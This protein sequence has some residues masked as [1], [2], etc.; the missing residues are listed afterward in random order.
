MSTPVNKLSNSGHYLRSKVCREP[1]QTP[2]LQMPSSP[3]MKRLGFGTGVDVFL[4]E[5]SPKF[6]KSMSPW[7]IKKISKRCNGIEEVKRLKVEASILKELNH[8]NIVGFRTFAK[9]HDGLYCLAMEVG[10]MSLFDLIELKNEADESPFPSWSI[11]KVALSITSALDYLHNE[12]YILHGDIKSGNV[13]I[14]GEFDYVKLCHFGVALPLNNDL[15]LSKEH[16]YVGTTCWS[17]KEAIE[18]GLITDRTDIFAFGIT[19]Y[20]ML[21]LAMPHMYVFPEEEL[22]DDP[23]EFEKDYEVAEEKFHQL[24]GTRPPLLTNKHDKSYATCI[25]VFWVCTNSLPIER[26]S[27]K[28]LYEALM[29]NEDEIAILPDPKG[30][31]EF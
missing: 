21:T 28:Q 16:E 11:M 25:E 15:T 6:G 22:Y 7:A 5:R 30:K 23:D 20:E 8:E 12:K 13:L 10:K 4:I 29:S 9:S 18:G 31:L 19:I 24:L 26:P 14:Q 3:F 1:P 2:I 27:S 17:A